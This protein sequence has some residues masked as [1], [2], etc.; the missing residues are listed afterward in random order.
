[1]HLNGVRGLGAGDVTPAEKRAFNQ[2]SSV[3]SASYPSAPSL[4]LVSLNLH[5]KAPH[6][7]GGCSAYLIVPSVMEKNSQGYINK[8]LCLCWGKFTSPSRRH[9]AKY[10]TLKRCVTLCHVVTLCIVS[11]RFVLLGVLFPYFIMLYNSVNIS[12]HQGFY[13]SKAPYVRAP[14]NMVA[15]SKKS[16][17][18]T[19]KGK[20]VLV[21]ESGESLPHSYQSEKKCSRTGRLNAVE[22]VRVKTGPDIF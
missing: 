21:K 22:S 4:P 6:S 17:Q 9:Q 12:S 11:G 20:Q 19:I 1:M 2:K 10:M 15:S 13:F 3:I 5:S 14:T 8:M 7:H 16:K 18:M